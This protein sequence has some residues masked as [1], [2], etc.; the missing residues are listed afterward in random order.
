MDV[1]NNYSGEFPSLQL[2]IVFRSPLP[3]G[4]E[5]Y[6]PNKTTSFHEDDVYNLLVPRGL[7]KIHY[8]AHRLYPQQR[9]GQRD[10][11]C[12]LDDAYL[13][14]SRR[15]QLHLLQLLCRLNITFVDAQ[16]DD[17]PSC[18]PHQ[19]DPTPHVRPAVHHHAAHPSG[20]H[21][22]TRDNSSQRTSDSLCRSLPKT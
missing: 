5:S 18:H 2:L 14:N 7:L 10:R 12:R 9:Q 3:A 20:I 8:T 17:D 4:T 16:R 1:I 13:L 6:L 22:N 21:K 11:P 15:H 19:D